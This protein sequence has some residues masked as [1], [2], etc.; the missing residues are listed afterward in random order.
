MDSGRGNSWLSTAIAS[1][2]PFT[3]NETA[4]LPV[5]VWRVVARRP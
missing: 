5:G 3:F 1:G 4:S 2:L